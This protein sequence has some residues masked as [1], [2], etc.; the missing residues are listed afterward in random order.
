MLNEVSVASREGR[1]VDLCPLSKE[2]EIDD[3]NEFVYEKVNQLGSALQRCFF[4]RMPGRQ[5]VPLCV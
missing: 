2:K 3:M 5:R 1:E 4:R